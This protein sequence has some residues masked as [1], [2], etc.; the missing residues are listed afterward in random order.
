MAAVAA[1]LRGRAGL[2]RATPAVGRLAP[3]PNAVHRYG[4]PIDRQAAAGYAGA[5]GKATR[6]LTHQRPAGPGR[7]T[8]RQRTPRGPRRGA[9]S[10]PVHRARGRPVQWQ[11]ASAGAA[12]RGW[13]EQ[14]GRRMPWSG[15]PGRQAAAFRAQQHCQGPLGSAGGRAAGP[16]SRQQLPVRPNRHP[17]SGRRA[18]CWPLRCTGDR[19]RLSV[20]AAGGPAGRLRTLGGGWSQVC[21]SCGGERGLTRSSR[22]LLWE[23]WLGVSAEGG[24]AGARGRQHAHPPGCRAAGAHAQCG[25]LAPPPPLLHRLSIE[26]PVHEC[27][28]FARPLARRLAATASV[29]GL[30]PGPLGRSRCCL[31]TS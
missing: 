7:P 19:C 22:G 5:G 11:P 8:A 25:L 12:G 3:L 29:L 20:G 1:G 14:K 10:R 9:R 6:A 26:E 27:M 21:C 2:R 15:R 18:A 17:R 31:P 16:D 4:P 30:D 28:M 24:G 13:G 23:A